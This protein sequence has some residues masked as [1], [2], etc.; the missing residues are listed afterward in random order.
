ME[1][2]S[3]H[4]HTRDSAKDA[5]PTAARTVALAKQLGYPALG[6]TDHGTISGAVDFYRACRKN[7]IEPLIGVEAY[8]ALDRTNSRWGPDRTPDEAASPSGLRLR[9]MHAC[10]VAYD[11]AG[12]RNLCELVT[13]SN[14]NYYHQPVLDLA[15][16]AD[17]SVEGRLDGL[18]MT[19][20][21]WF[22]L[23]PMMLRHGDMASADNLLQALSGWFKG[24]LYVEVQNHQI[25]KPEEH[26]DDDLQG[27]LLLAIAERNDLPMVI[28]Q[29]S[30][31]LYQQDQKIHDAFKLLTTWNTGDPADSVFPGDGYH[32]VDE[33]W[34]EEHHHPDIFKRGMAGLERIY[35]QAKLRVPE[36]ETYQLRVPDTTTSGDPDAELAH[37]VAD[38]LL[39][40]QANKR[41][42]KSQWKTYQARANA[43]LEV[44]HNS[45]FAGYL[46]LVKTV[47][48]WLREQH[49]DFR[50]RGSASGSLVC[51]LLGITGYDPIRWDLS[52]E[53]FLSHDRT[54][55]PDVDLDVEHTRR[56][57]VLDWLLDRF[58]ACIISTSHGY[59]IR[60]ADS[61]TPA[62][63]LAIAYRSHAGALNQ[64]VGLPAS[65]QGIPHAWQK[66]M[67]QIAEYNG[68]NP[69][70]TPIDPPISSIS[71][72]PAGVLIA[73]D[74]Q[75]L[76]EMPKR[77]IASSGSM[78][79][80]Y[81]QKQVEALGL[82][83]LDVLGLRTL[84]AL[85]IA[86]EQVGVKAADF[87]MTDRRTY[88]RITSGRTDGMFQLEGGSAR[89]GVRRMKL[90][91]FTDLIA[92]MA[93]FR[94]AANESGAT[95]AYLRRKRGDEEVPVRHE[96]LSRHT[97]DTYG[98]LIYQEQAL[99]ILKD[100]GLSISEIEEAR[101]AIKASNENVGN[102][103]AQLV[104]LTDHIRSL[105][106][107]KGLT[108]ADI[109]W[110]IG[111]VHAFAGYS[112]NRAHATAYA[113]LAYQTAYM[114]T[115]YPTAFWLGT[116]IAN[117]DNPGIPGKPKPM[118]VYM[119]EARTDGVKIVGAHINRSEETFTTDGTVIY[120]GFETIK[121]VGPRAAAEL[122]LHQPYTSLDDLARRVSTRLVSGSKDLGKGHSPSACAGV[123]GALHEAGALRTLTREEPV[124]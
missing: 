103:K 85:R 8:V 28:T 106:H 24:N 95:D 68:V 77:W 36:L 49:I 29:D 114:A 86:E 121:G 42:P 40:F 98:V 55:P 39:I 62:G 5:L 2:W 61:D 89:W 44:I 20:G 112:F 50:T 88:M 82:V 60:A 4:T 91:K 15:D 6:L 1:W 11:L 32:M 48:D 22:G 117:R 74:A 53:R 118:D 94:P 41:F 119:R 59:K 57:E 81:R 16:L 23:L 67:T 111:V 75:T 51:W 65:F 93:L 13:R 54:K 17:A 73:P 76:E 87:P 92:A 123:I 115:H 104:A 47:C 96:L 124:A 113:F 72:H 31:Y 101:S 79:T 3:L 90:T 71:Q 120:R 83:K 10:I 38:T 69:D 46:W 110:L 109:A 64:M 45:G 105:A 52:F 100:L 30:H 9:T 108:E 84:T 70:G 27:H 102:A 37:W 80:A 78:V 26:H 116:L 25:R 99:S 33:E 19:T 66:A 63:A 34:M 58:Y 18:L 35:A 21:C 12:Y 122:V 14:D 43:E 97:S 7:D 107:D 56:R